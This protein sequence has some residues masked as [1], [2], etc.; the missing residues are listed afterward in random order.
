MRINGKSYFNVSILYSALV[1]TEYPPEWILIPSVLPLFTTTSHSISSSTLKP[2]ISTVGFTDATRFPT[3]KPTEPTTKVALTSESIIRP[4]SI[5]TIGTHSAATKQPQPTIAASTEKSSVTTQ[6]ATAAVEATTTVSQFI[7]IVDNDND[8]DNDNES[9]EVLSTTD[10]QK[11]TMFDELLETTTAI[12]TTDYTE[13]GETE[14]ISNHTTPEPAPMS[15]Q[16]VADT[17]A[18]IPELNSA[19]SILATSSESSGTLSQ[20]T[21]QSFG[22][23]PNSVFFFL[24]LS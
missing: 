21:S 22:M 16:P 14:R 17:T 18:K 6:A 15:T 12:G 4:I 13:I 9:E 23:C 3:R 2:D 8:N 19:P 24:K 10:Q 5:Q 11:I 1:K 20:T 7:D